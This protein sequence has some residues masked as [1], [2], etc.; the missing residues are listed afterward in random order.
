[1]DLQ[2]E[3]NNMNEELKV[4]TASPAIDKSMLQKESKG[5]YETL[6]KNLGY[7]LMWI[8]I[9]SVPMLAGAFFAEGGLR[10]LLIGAFLVYEIARMLMVHKLKH[11]PPGLDYSEVTKPML[12]RQLQ[13]V[14]DMLNAEQLWG[15]LF[16]PLSTPA[17][18]IAYQLF[19]GKELSALYT[20]PHFLLYVVMCIV[21][22][23]LGL[24][25]AKK[26]N[27][28]AFSGHIKRLAE[29]IEQ[30]N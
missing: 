1:M 12:S 15:Y 24:I 21:F 4:T 5:L 9:L 19:A 17:G 8:R 28:I 7:K 10:Y 13:M 11:M 30:M 22:A 18:L 3:W 2:S 23:G 26:M 29:N 20:G 16:I 14:K 6:R 27:A 25:M